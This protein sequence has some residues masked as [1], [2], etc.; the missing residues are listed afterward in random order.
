MQWNLQVISN[1]TDPINQLFCTGWNGS[2]VKT[3]AAERGQVNVYMFCESSWQDIL[4]PYI[5]NVFWES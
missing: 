1:L 4:L 2:E 3:E 5:C